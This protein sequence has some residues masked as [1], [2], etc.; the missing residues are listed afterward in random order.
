[1]LQV[2]VVGTG[3]V[4]LVTGT[5]LAH[6]GRNVI[7]VDI[8]ERKI[9]MLRD[10]KSPIYEPG[11]DQL[12]T[13][14]LHRGNL[15]VLNNFADS[16]QQSEIVFIAVGTPPL[17]S[18]KANLAYVEAVAREIGRSLDCAQRRVIV[19]KSTVPIGSGNWVEMLIRE[20]LN[21]NPVYLEKQAAV[22]SAH[23]DSE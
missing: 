21:D 3:Y 7:C 2:C 9:A 16:V 10:G 12:I 20:G 14:G 4:G 8:D 23:A 18:G 5:C 1:E 13:A 15:T 17:P 22:G 19:N 6:L 11:L